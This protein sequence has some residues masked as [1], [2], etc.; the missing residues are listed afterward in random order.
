MSPQ[1][2]KK[3]IETQNI[4]WI[5]IH[6]TD[7]IGGLRVLH[8]PAERF[9]KD[10][11]LKK[12]SRFDGS[13]VGFRKVEKSDIIALPDPSTFLVLP[14]ENGEAMIRADLY[15]VEMD[16]YRAGPRNIMKR[17]VEKAR[18]QGFDTVMISPDMEFYAF[19]NEQE[20][21]AKV[22]DNEGYFIP[23]LL[24]NAKN[25]RKKLSDVLMESGYHVK[26]HHHETGKSQHEIEIKELEAMAAADFCSYFKYVAREIATAYHFEITFMPKPFSHEIWHARPCRI[27]F[28]REEHVR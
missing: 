20:K 9:L 15:D 26:Y 3:Q 12:G 16:S 17:A 7:L 8:V 6:F 24:D 23:S 27:L 10:E 2:I 11:L 21:Y 4:R 18:L 14:Y 25:Y 22:K 1:E 19:N 13:S 5:Q 28:E